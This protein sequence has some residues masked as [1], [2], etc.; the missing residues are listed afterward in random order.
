MGQL[1]YAK[2]LTRSLQ[3]PVET[4]RR[5]ADN[6]AAVALRMLDGCAGRMQVMNALLIRAVE[7]TLLQ[8][9][10]RGKLH[11]TVHTCVGQEFTGVAVA[12]ALRRGDFVTSNHRCH[13]HFIAATGNWRGLV[14]EVVGNADGVCAGVGSSQH[15]FAENFLSNGQQGGLLPVAAGLAL[16]RQRRGRQEIVVSYIG[17]GT[18]GEGIV[19]ETMNLASLWNLPHLIV[20]ENNAYSQS[21]PQSASVA[22]D[23]AA[24][25][26]AFGLGVHEA[27]T[28]NPKQLMETAAAA[29]AEV[30]HT[31]RPA[32]L[33]VRTYRLNAH[34][35]GDDERNAQ[36]RDWFADADPLNRIVA[37]DRGMAESY[38]KL[39]EKVAAYG[40]AALAKPGLAA[41]DYFGDQL[42]KPAAP[43]GWTEVAP[44]AEGG[45]FAA[46]LND[47]LGRR[48]QHDPA[49]FLLGE[50]IAD[51]YG[52][53]F[54]VTR[55]LQNSHPER[56]LTTPISEAAIV[57]VGIGL[58]IAG[59]RPLVEIMFGDFMTHVIDQLV[60]NASKAFHMY[61]RAVACPVVVRTPMGGRRGYGPTHSQS[62]ERFL[63]GLDNTATLAL[64]TLVPAAAQL[65]G[66]ADLACPTILIENK[67]DYARRTYA[68]P[69]DFVVES[70]GAVLPTVRVRPRHG[71]ANATVVAYGGMAR[72]VADGI[73][74]LFE[75]ADALVELIVPTAIHPLDLRPIL[76]SVARTGVLL[77]A[78][79]GPTAAGVGAEI[80]AGV[81]EAGH[82]ACRVRRIGGAPVPVPSAP[83]LEAMALPGVE[84]VA[85][86]LRALLE[87]GE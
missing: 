34:S 16:H 65:R 14:D 50:D 70:D 86:A 17:E 39:R 66:L 53:A 42:P 71:R 32:F 40:E 22:G 27:D 20:C 3:A 51:P 74:Q 73:D 15:L 85:A 75:D 23:V 9:F 83:A 29:V 64:H 87:N 36:E 37:A 10:G 11:G 76:E 7:E 49:V 4:L 58:A 31:G 54:K 62:L 1:L 59:N 67:T 45:R 81:L 38:A 60:N 63:V 69:D 57:G 80:A 44:D 28:W 61:N 6:D 12:A 46:Q 68:A 21:T 52:G 79:E 84:Q 43:A 33:L 26:A 77:V 47:Y 2:D 82:G 5:L 24:R 56:V 18:L 19:Y 35:K 48:L 41:D 30:R 72:L 78:E 25:A 55:G 13:G 8:L